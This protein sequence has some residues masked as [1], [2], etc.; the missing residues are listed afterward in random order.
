[1]SSSE[2]IVRAD[3]TRVA[4][5]AAS[6]FAAYKPFPQQPVQLDQRESGTT[7]WQ[8]VAGTFMTDLA[9]VVRAEVVQTNPSQEYRFTFLPTTT[10]GG[11]V[12]RI[13]RLGTPPPP[14]A[15]TAATALRINA[16]GTTV[17]AAT[18]YRTVLTVTLASGRSA[19]AGRSVVLRH[20]RTGV[21]AWT[22]GPVVKTGSSG[23][24]AV[25]VAQTSTS[26][27]YQFLFAG[28]VN[29]R[30]CASGVLTIKRR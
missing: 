2:L 19:V 18:R 4:K 28:D 27:Q 24:T 3:G 20:R 21:A 12:T 22:V 16:P 30:P 1:M 26:E 7:A 15:P 8:S 25:T 10:H 17:T 11:S 13:V 9:A 23:R 6:L 29:Y 14:P 5:L